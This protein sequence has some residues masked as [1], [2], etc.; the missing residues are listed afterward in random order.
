[1][2]KPK[3]QRK[4]PRFRWIAAG[5]GYEAYG[6]IS[7]YVKFRKRKGPFKEKQTPLGTFIQLQDRELYVVRRLPRVNEVYNPIT[8]FDYCVNADLLG[9]GSI[10]KHNGIMWTYYSQ[11]YKRCF[12]YDKTKANFPIFCDCGGYPLIKGTLDFIYPE[13]LAVFY[14]KF[15]TRGMGIDIPTRVI[16]N[17][18]VMKCAKY[19]K[20]NTKQLLKYV[21]KDVKIY[22][23]SHGTGYKERRDYI[24]MVD[25]PG[26]DYW[27]I[28]GTST[29]NA[30]DLVYNIFSVISYKKAKSYHVFGIGGF[31]VMPI[32]AWIGK[33]YDITSDSS[34]A[35]QAGRATSMYFDIR[36]SVTPV[37]VGYFQ[38][39][40]VLHST[41]SFT[42]LS[43]SCPICSAIG[44]PELFHKSKMSETYCLC[45]LHNI[46]MMTN[47]ASVWNDLAQECS[48]NQ[49]KKVLRKYM[50]RDTNLWPILIDYVEE[51]VSTSF[52]KANRKFTS[53]LTLFHR[54]DSLTTD[55][56]SIFGKKG[57]DHEERVKHLL[58]NYKRYY[59]GEKPKPMPKD[60]KSVKNLF[61]EKM[62]SF[63]GLS[64]RGGG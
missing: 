45:V 18:L 21:D 28:G 53:F 13:D 43:C 51:I 50:K 14:N 37:K 32:L 63:H 22:N 59:A 44:T 42:S 39:G 64:K 3:N 62:I 61:V 16:R 49:Y 35:L 31:Q 27:A 36:G 6:G 56:F 11:A 54:A 4:N 12:G 25:I 20:K 38:G 24:D 9:L 55:T 5:A 47:Y 15:A 2:S 52:E 29:V 10:F 1:M 34:S 58:N 17:N 40:D 7:I 19:Q 48:S 30:F 33:Y 46:F 8:G 57:D 41:R 60:L 26:I 23:I